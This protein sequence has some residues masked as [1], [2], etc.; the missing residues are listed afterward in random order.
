MF[1]TD[2]DLVYGRNMST[3]SN[4]TAVIDPKADS[5]SSEEKGTG[6]ETAAKAAKAFVGAHVAAAKF[7]GG[8]VSKLS[9]K[10]ADYAKSDD[11]AEK[12]DFVKNK[13]GSAFSGLKDK[14]AA[15]AAEHKKS[16]DEKISAANEYDMEAN[17][18]VSPND[19][20]YAY[21]TNTNVQPTPMSNSPVYNAGTYSYN[22]NKKSPII[23]ILIGV[24]SVLLVVLG[25][26]F[27]MLLTKNKNENNSGTNV[28]HDDSTGTTSETE[29]TVTTD[30]E[31]TEKT[32]NTTSTVFVESTIDDRTDIDQNKVKEAYIRKLTEFAK[33]DDF[34]AYEYASK[35]ALYD[36]DNDGIDELIIQYMNTVGNA[37]K[38]YYYKNGEYAEI[39]NCCESSF[40]ICP[41]E[42]CV[43]WYGYGGGTL[44]SVLKLGKQGNS[45]D[46]LLIGPYL[47]TSHYTFN[48]VGISKS[49]Y[50]NIM[51]KY[52]AMNWVSPTFY[53][54]Q[55][56]LSDDIVYAKP[57][58]YDYFLAVVDTESTD[59]N[60]RESPSTDSKILGTVPKVA[61]VT[62]AYIDGYTDWYKV[63]YSKKNLK[64]Y[65]SAQYITDSDE[66]KKKQEIQNSNNKNIYAGCKYIENAPADMWFY[67]TNNML[68]GTVSTQSAVLN[69]YDGPGTNYTVIL[70][71]PKDTSVEILGMNSAWAYIKWNVWTGQQ[72][73]D[74]Y[75]YVS[76][77]FLSGGHG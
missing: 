77:D 17:Y 25:V 36:I 3:Q 8:A 69:M 9:K 71:L 52:D 49:E 54:F 28:M 41:E 46:E 7:A 21:K 44:R 74:Y 11:A 13:A 47:D 18:D 43:Q 31:S 57:R 68:V 58:E 66:Y 22:E 1:M 62:A 16:S 38:L 73:I 19:T 67:E 72:S 29:G 14:A 34:N 30:V 48:D 37:E 2:C 45:L 53:N 59:L 20:S 40:T 60:V 10:A 63:E 24:I 5:E 15:F 12:M 23:Y 61:Y 32:M 70:Y 35:Y 50:E 26:L 51:A 27:G 6:M 42:H 39:A 75:G 64:G 56:I 33:S 55:T 76:R 4:N 65:A